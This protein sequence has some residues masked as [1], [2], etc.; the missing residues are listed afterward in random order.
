VPLYPFTL[1]TTPSGLRSLYALI[2][3][4]ARLLLNNLKLPEYLWSEVTNAAIYILNQIL[5]KSLAWKTPHE[6]LYLKLEHKPSYIQNQLD[7][8]N[9]KVYG[10]KTYV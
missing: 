2:I 3:K 7:L 9:L 6:A 5:T 4:K 10:Y 1:I 8:K